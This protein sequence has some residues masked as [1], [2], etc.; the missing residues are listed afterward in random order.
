MCIS[1]QFYEP[2]YFFFFLFSKKLA[3]VLFCC[4]YV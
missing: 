2:L 3:S 1:L 4:A